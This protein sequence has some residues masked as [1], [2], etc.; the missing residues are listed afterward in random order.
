MQRIDALIGRVMGDLKK[1]AKGNPM[2]SGMLD[3]IESGDSRKGEKMADNLCR[4]M[5]ISRDEAVS[6]ARRFFGL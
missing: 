4:S 6:Q 3:V 2:A 5:G 1:K